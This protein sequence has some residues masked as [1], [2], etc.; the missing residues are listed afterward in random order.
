LISIF[1]DGPGDAGG[2]PYYILDSTTLQP[3]YIDGFFQFATNDTAVFVN[4]T[5]ICT[6]T[7]DQ[8][9]CVP[10][11]GAELS[12]NEMYGDDENSGNYFVPQDETHTNTSFTLAVLGWSPSDNRFTLDQVYRLQDVTTFPLP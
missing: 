3:T 6:Y 12:G 4:P 11:P 2:L 7:P 10:L 5:D 8:P 1:D 9:A